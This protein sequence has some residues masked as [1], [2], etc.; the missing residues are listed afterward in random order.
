MQFMAA[1]DFFHIAV[2]GATP[3]D[4]RLN[5]TKRTTQMGRNDE[6][7]QHRQHN[8]PENPTAPDDPIGILQPDAV[9]H[10]AKKN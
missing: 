3:V 6:I 1:E 5:N 10:I 9:G 4:K 7:Q 8:T 2:L